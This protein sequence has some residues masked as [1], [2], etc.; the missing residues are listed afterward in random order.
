VVGDIDRLTGCWLADDPSASAL[1]LAS[2]ERVR[3]LDAA[4]IGRFASS[5]APLIGGHWIRWHCGAELRDEKPWRLS[6]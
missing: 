5:S 2:Y 3:P 4:L 1:A 6:G